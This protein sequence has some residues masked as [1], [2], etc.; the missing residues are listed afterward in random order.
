MSIISSGFLAII[1]SLFATAALILGATINEPRN[2]SQR[3]LTRA[4]IDR[5]MKPTQLQGSNEHREILYSDA[6]ILHSGGIIRIQL[7]ETALYGINHGREAQ[8]TIQ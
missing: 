8:V 6:D 4:D 7:G 2:Q 3:T 5:M 1:V